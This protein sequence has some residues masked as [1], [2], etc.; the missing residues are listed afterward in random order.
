MLETEQLLQAK[1]ANTI[2]LPTGA[3]TGDNAAARA[4]VGRLRG[5][6]LNLAALPRE[7]LYQLQDCTMTELRAREG[8]AVQA[9]SEQ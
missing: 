1:M 9:L 8:R 7:R 2:T 5:L 3:L 4:M 6:G